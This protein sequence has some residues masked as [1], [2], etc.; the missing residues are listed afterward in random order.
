MEG[1]LNYLD[2]FDN[3]TTTPQLKTV[4]NKKVI[5]EKKENPR[6]KVLCM[7]VE[8]RSVEGAQK[9]INKLQEWISNQE[10]KEHFELKEKQTQESPKYRIPPKKVLKNPILE[11]KSRA[12]DILN[13]LPERSDEVVISEEMHNSSINNSKLQSRQPQNETVA[14]HASALL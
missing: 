11:A 7:N 13:G 10:I 9:V 4:V 6:T 12:V 1:F 3:Q 5:A 8:I 2:Q 14:G